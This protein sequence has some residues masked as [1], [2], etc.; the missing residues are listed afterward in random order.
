MSMI[1]KFLLLFFITLTLFLNACVKIT[2]NEDFLKNTIEK[3]DESSLTEFQKLMLEDYE[4]MWEILRENYPLWGVIRRRGIDADKVYE[5]YRKQINTIENEIDFFNILNNTINSF[6]KIGHLNLLDYKFYKEYQFA[7][8]DFRDD[9]RYESCNDI[10]FNPEVEEAYERL[11]IAKDENKIDYEKYDL[12]LEEDKIN[13]IKYYDLVENEVAYIEIKSFSNDINYDGLILQNIYEKVKDYKHIVF[14][15]SK[16]RGGSTLYWKN[17]IVKPI[18]G[19]NKLSYTCYLLLQKGKYSESFIDISNSIYNELRPVKELPFFEN[20]NKDD[21]DITPYFFSG[22]DTIYSNADKKAVNGRIWVIISGDSYSATDE[23]AYFC[24]ETGFATL[25]GQTTK[26]DGF[27]LGT[28]LLKLP[29][30]QY[31]INFKP[32]FILNHDGSNNVEFG[33]SPDYYIKGD[34]RN[35][36]FINDCLKLIINNQ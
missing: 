13:N 10:L 14:D 29:S 24:K 6:Y 25:L 11:R 33:T 8:K 23:F 31:V 20:I 17:N 15:V 7:F 9:K 26:G 12:S 30:S 28:V 22:T 18:I 35:A 27:G 34:T 36:N 21:F 32:A 16:N 1:K 5:F 19:R 2:Q 4:Y 3:S